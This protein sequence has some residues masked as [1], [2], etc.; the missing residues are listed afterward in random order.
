MKTKQRAP[1]FSNFCRT[2]SLLTD[3]EVT[4]RL[5]DGDCTGVEVSYVRTLKEG[6]EQGDWTLKEGTGTHISL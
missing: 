6:T 3:A 4:T 1:T 5:D 2:S